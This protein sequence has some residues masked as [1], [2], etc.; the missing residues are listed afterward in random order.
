MILLLW[1]AGNVFAYDLVPTETSTPTMAKPVALPAQ[2]KIRDS[3]FYPLPRPPHKVEG[4]VMD[5][6]NDEDLAPQGAALWDLTDHQTLQQIPAVNKMDKRSGRYYWHPFKGWN[7]C[8]YRDGHLDWY[9]WHTGGSFHWILWWSG[10]FWWHDSYAQ[11]WLYFDQGFWWW[12]DPKGANQFQLFLDDGHYHACDANGVL[13]DDLLRAG[14]EEVETA[15][16]AKPSAT[17]TPGAKQGGHHGG[18]HL[19]GGTPGSIGTGMDGN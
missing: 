6:T 1:G 4:K 8:H 17:T 3:T 16:V 2:E 19:G 12:Q 15:P 7:Y 18:H 9:G 14:T 5:L 11:R 13:G 10:R